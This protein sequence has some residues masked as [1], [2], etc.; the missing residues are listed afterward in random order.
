MAGVFILALGGPVY[1]LALSLL[2][3]LTS[4]FFLRN[5]RTSITEAQVLEGGRVRF[6]TG[7]KS[8]TEVSASDIYRIEEL[9]VATVGEGTWEGTGFT[10]YVFG[11]QKIR[12]LDRW[13]HI[14]RSVQ[15]AS[16]AR[17]QDAF[18]ARLLELNPRIERTDRRVWMD[19][20]PVLS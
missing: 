20:P 3:L 2:G 14:A 7:V 1:F 11:E 6:M 16:V 8:V 12:N 5:L 18:V 17:D 15:D 13:F 9:M 10:V 19:P 4:L